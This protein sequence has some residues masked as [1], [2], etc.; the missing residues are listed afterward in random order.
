MSQPRSGKEPQSPHRT[1]TDGQYRDP[2]GHL[3]SGQRVLYPTARGQLLVLA[4]G[5]RSVHFRHAYS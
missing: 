2:D 1:H 4:G 5:D 3:R